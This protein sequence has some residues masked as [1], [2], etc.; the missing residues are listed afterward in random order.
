[1]EVFPGGSRNTDLD[2]RESTEDGGGSTE[3]EK[4]TG[5]GRSEGGDTV[6][7]TRTELKR[8]RRN[9]NHK[10]LMKRLHPK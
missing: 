7:G 1:M 6:T 9:I 8:P 3:T 5:R 4:M 2:L 10:L